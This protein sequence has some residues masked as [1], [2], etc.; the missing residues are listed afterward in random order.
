MPELTPVQQYYKGKTVFITGASGFMGK[1][2][3]EK[4]LYSCYELKE[5]IMICRAKRGK[6][7]EQRLEDMW[8]L[9]IF[10]RIKDERPEVLKKVTMYTG[11]ITLELLGLSEENLK[12]VTENT[13]IV[14]HMAATLK[15][16]GNLTDAVNMNLAGTRR[17]I[18]VAR[19]MKHL[20]AFVHLSTAFCNCDQE[21][22]YE[23]VYDFPHKPEELMRMAEWMDVPTMD[24]VTPKLLPPHPNTYT[25]TKRLAEIYVRDQYETM[26][27]II[28]RPSIVS[29]AYK[30]PLPGWVDSLNGPV[31]VMTAGARGVLRSMMCDL[32]LEADMIPVDVAINNLIIIPY[33][34]TQYKERPKEIPVFNLIMPRK[35]RKT[36]GW[37]LNKGTELNKK[38]PLSWP[39]WYPNPN[40][41]T[42]KYYHMFNMIFFMWLPALL[43]DGILTI[44]GKR[45]FMIHVQKRIYVGLE[46]LQFFTTRKWDF[47]N[48]RLLTLLDTL[49]PADLALFEVQVENREYDIDGYLLTCCFGGRQYI[50]K[51]S[52]ES[53]PKSR[54]IFNCMYVLD[55]V[56]KTFICGWF[57]YWLATKI[58]I[59][60]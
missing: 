53:F 49:S 41:T 14:F 51:E 20:E 47:R 21:V 11:D 9:P 17:A 26:P 37:V 15:L 5:I 31:G 1:V 55:K 27:V 16:E 3:L 39:L 35:C 36:W 52:L 56:C 7:P 34:F 24:A 23:K 32:S 60:N 40:V 38:Y 29:P 19:K 13:N 46:V 18:E 6:T 58:G 50:C 22:M 44:M 28:A 10:Q 12:H 45:R 42:N 33:G 48:E 25:Y 30:D 2:L 8:K 57:F 59:I 4:L 54:L 43:I